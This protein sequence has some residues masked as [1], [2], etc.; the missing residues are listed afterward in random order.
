M[1]KSG[2]ILERKCAVVLWN[3][4]SYT[5]I[6]LLESLG[7]NYTSED[8][9][10]ISVMAKLVPDYDEWWVSP[11]E[12]PGAWKFVTQQDIF[13]DWFDREKYEQMFREYVCDWWDAHVLVDKQIV[14]LSSGYYLLKRCDVERLCKDVVVM[15]DNSHVGEMALSTGGEM[16]GYTSIDRM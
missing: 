1:F 12:Q 7:I 14:E 8:A 13:P 6:A 11:K 16:W 2:V 4:D 5:Q 15:M 9:Q 3:D 10:R